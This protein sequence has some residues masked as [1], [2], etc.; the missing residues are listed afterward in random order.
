MNTEAMPRLP[1][2]AGT[3][4]RDLYARLPEDE[5]KRIHTLLCCAVDSDECKVLLSDQLSL[6]GLSEE[7]KTEVVNSLNHGFWKTCNETFK[8]LKQPR[9]AFDHETV[10]EDLTKGVIES[11]D[12]LFDI[13]RGFYEM[14]DKLFPTIEDKEAANIYINLLQAQ[15][16]LGGT[17]IDD[18]FLNE[19]QKKFLKRLSN[20]E[21]DAF[22]EFLKEYLN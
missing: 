4:I 22:E 1:L 14:T 10:I 13:I 21:L 16:A 15:R 17:D 7:E 11:L 19:E 3:L 8:D 9:S 12:A 20:E 5:L 6:K 2:D 18:D